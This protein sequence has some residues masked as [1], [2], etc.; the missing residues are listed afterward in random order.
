MSLSFDP[1]PTYDPLV[2]EDK[3]YISDFWNNYIQSLVQTL[4]TYLTDHGIFLPRLTTAQR[5]AIQSPQDGQM[6]YN[7]T[8]LSAQYRRN[9]V[10]VNFP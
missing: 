8:A 10:W 5:D 9:G 7:T 1:P 6:I 4:T 3:T 2:K